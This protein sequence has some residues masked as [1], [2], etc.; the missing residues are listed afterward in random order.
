MSVFT[1]RN[2]LYL[3][4]SSITYL[5]TQKLSTAKTIS[6]AW[7]SIRKIDMKGSLKVFWGVYT[8]VD[9]LSN[10]RQAVQHGFKLAAGTNSYADYPGQQKENIHDFIARKYRHPWKKPPFFDK[11]VKRN[12]KD[13]THHESIFYH[14]IEWG[15]D[16]NKKAQESWQDLELRKLVKAKNLKVFTEKYYRELASWYSLPCQW[17]K[18][19]YPK[20]PVGI[21][22]PQVFNRDYWGFSKPSQLE[23]THSSDLKLWKYIDPHID[24]YISSSYIF[25]DLPDSIYYLAANIEENYRLSRKF[26]NKPLYAFLWLRYHESNQKLAGQELPD[27]M[28]EAAAVI[29]FFT[30][31]K[32]SVLWGW[33][34]KAQGQPYQTLP[35][36]VNSLERVAKLSAKIGRAKLV[37]DQPA[38]ELWQA[39]VP[40]IRKL[41]VSENEWIIMA[42]NPWQKDSDREIVTV[43]CGKKSVKVAISGKHTEI[44]HLYKNTLEKISK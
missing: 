39:K 6:V 40:L 28:V 7:N 26:S 42:I 30:G 32:G 20:Q 12:I 31:A 19:M 4:S 29:P 11:I 35:T 18:Q 17:S 9:D 5:L 33:E 38:Y 36:F 21:Y 43:A 25:Y 22:G 2:F 27:Y 1:R 13:A 16:I 44:Y 14:D 41:R 23:E 10:Q 34:P 3:F 24:F 15:I 8:G 37:I